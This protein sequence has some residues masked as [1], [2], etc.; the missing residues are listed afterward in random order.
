MREKMYRFMQGRYGLDGF[1]NALVWIALVIIL[2]NM[3]IKSQLLSLLCTVVIIFAYYR[4]FSRNHTK[5]IMENRWY[6][7]H[8]QRI[9]KWWYKLK[10]RTKQRLNYRI[11]VC[12][13][14]KQ[15][16]RVPKGKGKIEVSCPK[17]RDKFIRRS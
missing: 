14:C 3:F 2:L 10:N 12:P 4:I 1:S 17:C 13:K 6:Y 5:R 9:R 11:F 8:T 7:D 16:V 15:K